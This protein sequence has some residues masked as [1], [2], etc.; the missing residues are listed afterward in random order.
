MIYTVS[1]RI[2]QPI[3][4][5]RYKE[6][7]ASTLPFTSLIT[8]YAKNGEFLKKRVTFSTTLPYNITRLVI[9]FMVKMRSVITG[10]F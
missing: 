4:A 5:S 2:T 3:Y 10:V 1:K 6:S 8:P 7:K 9:L